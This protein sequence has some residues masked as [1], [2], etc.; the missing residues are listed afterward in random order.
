MRA[1]LVTLTL[2]VAA[3]QVSAQTPLQ[4]F[5]GWYCDFF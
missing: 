2:L 1:I 3:P 4:L 5:G